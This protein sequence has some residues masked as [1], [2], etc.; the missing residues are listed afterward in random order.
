METTTPVAPSSPASPYIAHTNDCAGMAFEKC[1]N[2][3]VYIIT[4]ADHNALK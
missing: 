4:Q 2:A 3:D 1:G